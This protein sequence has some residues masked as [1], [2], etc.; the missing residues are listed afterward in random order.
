M[1][2]TAR[3]IR[4]QVEEDL[5]ATR[6]Q[7]DRIASDFIGCDT[8]MSD[9]NS[10]KT[11]LEK[12]AESHAQCRVTQKA[13]ASKLTMC[14]TLLNAVKSNETNLCDRRSLTQSPADLV[15]L[16]R[17][18]T[19]ESLGMW[20]EDMKETFST[21]H[22]NWKKD[23]AACQQAKALIGP[24]ESLCRDAEEALRKQEQECDD[25]LNNLEMSSCSW[26][27]G[28]AERCD[29]YETCFASV[30]TRYSVA[31]GK[32]NNSVAHWRKSWLAA[33]RLECMANA[34]SASN[35][36]QAKMHACNGENIT[37]MSFIKID[38]NPPPEQAVC[39]RPEIYPGSNIYKDLVYNRI[40]PGVAV[41]QPSLC[42]W[43]AKGTSCEGRPDGY[44]V[45]R[46]DD[47]RS[48]RV[49]CKDGW[50]LMQRRTSASVS[51]ER[52]WSDYA[53]GFGD[54][55]TNFWLGNDNLNALTQN[56][57][58]LRVNL[59]DASD[60]EGHAEYGIF[61]V[62]GEAEKYKVQFGGYQG[63]AGDA[64]AFHNGQRF[65][66]F[67]ADNDLWSGGNCAVTYKGGWW[68]RGCH[69]ANLNGRYEGPGKVSSFATGIVWNPWRGYHYS[70]KSCSMWVK[71]NV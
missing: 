61:S 5:N 68:Y 23:H 44:R 54:E 47:R 34:M 57:A 69:G 46:P 51:F 20:L 21:R 13:L 64:L 55:E 24:Q 45:I 19:E 22:D 31:V 66:T 39:P 38:F 25:K 40:P 29:S 7:L 60:Q 53:R 3:T 27:T 71:P 65:T 28:S 37:N 50:L 56:G 16:C 4:A 11:E 1:K 42:H 10:H 52:N 18:T 63:T 35:V 67:D 6:V 59:I 41:R 49:Y 2:E 62:A 17:P 14:K 32:A 43:S 26:A 15:S 70:M 36:D 48:I 8:F 30:Q 12:Q 9:V 33:A 58:R